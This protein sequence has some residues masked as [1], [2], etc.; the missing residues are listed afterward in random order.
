MS[1]TPPLGYIIEEDRTPAQQRSHENIVNTMQRFQITA[2]PHRGPVKVQLT[3]LWKDSRVVGDVGFAFNRFRQIT[4]SCVGAGGGQ[5]LFTLGAVQRCLPGGATKAF[6]PF[7]PFNYGRSRA[8]GGDRGPGEGSL[9]S[10]FAQTVAKEGIIGIHE[11]GLPTFDRGDGLA[12]TESQEMAWSDGASSLVTAFLDEARPHPVGTAAPMR[13]TDD[14][15]AAILNGYPGTF[16]CDRFIGKAAIVG[17]GADAVCVGKWDG[18]GGH[19]QS[20][21]DYWDHPTLGPLFGILNNWSGDTYPAD[22]GGLPTCAC[23][24]KE[25]DVAEAMRYHAEVYAFSHLSWFPAQ[26]AVLDWSSILP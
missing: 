6:I 9:G 21:H 5:A 18:Q 7:W 22:P 13:S 3:K 24:V 4:G 16:A 14:M 1:T 12:L 8:I 26:P 19:Q 10:W 23:W 15:R 20:F 25:V 17:S 11:A 2:A